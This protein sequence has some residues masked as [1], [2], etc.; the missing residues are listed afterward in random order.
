MYAI[1]VHKSMQIDA[2]TN[3]CLMGQI[4]KTILLSM[5]MLFT[6]SLSFIFM[7]NKSKLLFSLE[8][9]YVFNISFILLGDLRVKVN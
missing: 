7:Q 6:S 9:K 2:N 3:K 1:V 5:K 4:R 8:V